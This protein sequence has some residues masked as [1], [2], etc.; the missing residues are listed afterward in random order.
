MAAKKKTTNK[1]EIK[2]EDVLVE[3]IDTPAEESMTEAAEKEIPAPVVEKKVEEKPKKETKT[4]NKKAKYE[5]GSIVYITKDAEADLNGFN[6]FPQ[7]KKDTYTVEA[8]DENTGVYTL[9]RLK[10][11]VKLEERF[12]VSPDERAQDQINRLQF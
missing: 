6:L 3:K 7:Y 8:Y 1:E 2:E 9:R 12:I 10:L 11:L 5:V 4:K